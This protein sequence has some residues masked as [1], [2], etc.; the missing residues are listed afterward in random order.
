MGFLSN[1]WVRYFDRTHP[2]IKQQVLTDMQGRVPEITDHTE[3]NI[4]VK[5]LD[6]WSA[7]VE[8]LGYYIDFAA[9]EAHLDSARLY[10]SG[11]SIAKRY[12]YRAKSYS[13]AS[14]DLVF[15]LSATLLA[16]FTI[17]AGAVVQTAAGVKFRTTATKTIPAGQLSVVVPAL[18]VERVLG[19]SLGNATGNADLE[20]L[21]PDTLAD[22]SVVLRVNSLAWSSQQHFGY[23]LSS[24]THFVQSVNK[25]QIPTI[26]FGSGMN[27]L[28][29]PAGA[30]IDIDYDKTLG[31]DGNVGNNTVT[32]IVSNLGLPTGV[33]MA[34]TN[35]E[36]ASG[37]GGV[38]TLAQLKKR[39]P[40]SF[41]TRERAVTDTDYPAVAELATGVA[42]AGMFFNCGKTVDIYIV[43]DNGGVA[44]G[45]LLANTQ[46]WMDERK[47]TTTFIRMFAAGEVRMILT[48]NIQVKPNYTN[49]TVV[50]NV[51]NRLADFISYKFQKIQGTVQLSDIYE[52]IEN[53]DG[54]QYSE[55]VSMTPIPYARPATP[56]TPALSWARQI[57]TTSVSTINWIVQM[58]SSTQYQLIK[59]NVY[60][61]TFAVGTPYADSDIIFTINTGA[62]ALNDEWNFYTYPYTGTLV[63]AEPSL[64]VS[65]ASD[66]TVNATGGL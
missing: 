52:V 51:Q 1:T 47:M 30:A 10:R 14:T 16:P 53:T 20:I 21:V 27:G 48:L 61:G 28:I 22:G 24:D 43:P 31:I 12:N 25:D 23:S 4:F 59:N 35:P 57:Q 34:V 8:M 36:R 65:L 54:V 55:I 29:P 9:R 58:L 2:Q 11:I 15:T 42:L 26:T 60:I 7:L 44:S 37:G 32:T 3:S 62:Y 6:I 64:P 66:I 17:S 50:Q 39:I 41:R 46:T 19:Y 38:E 13:P 49:S 33:T 56:N 18:Q 40:L 63:L 45:A 5:L